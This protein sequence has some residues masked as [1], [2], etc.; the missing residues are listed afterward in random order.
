MFDCSD[1]ET[2][3]LSA[4]RTGECA[5]TLAGGRGDGTQWMVS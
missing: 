4:S 3:L 1:M 5:S 2:L